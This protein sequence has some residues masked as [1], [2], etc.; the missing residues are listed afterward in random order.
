MI[1]SQ[2]ERLNA[3]RHTF[4][5]AVEE[6][7]ELLDKKEDIIFEDFFFGA[8]GWIDRPSFLVFLIGAGPLMETGF[9]SVL[10]SGTGFLER[11][12]ES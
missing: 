12:L 5:A 6:I 2:L 3:W 4:S 11:D 7:A 9:V 10:H 1:D 8:F